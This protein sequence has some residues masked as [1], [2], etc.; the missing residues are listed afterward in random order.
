MS[1]LT[2]TVVVFIAMATLLSTSC[3]YFIR[4]YIPAAVISALLTVAGAQLA[5]YIYHGYIDPFITISSVTMWLI[6]F[7]TSLVVGILPLFRKR[8]KRDEPHS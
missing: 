2:I 5:F 8:L 1:Q 7:V 4:S 3:H 6:A